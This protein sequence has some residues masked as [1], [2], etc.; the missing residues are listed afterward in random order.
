[1]KEMAEERPSPEEMLERAAQ[2]EKRATRGQ[3]KVFFGSAPGVGKTYAMLEAAQARKREGRDVVIGWVETHGRVET[4]AMTRGLERVAPRQVDYR[5]IVMQDFDLDAAL[6]RRPEILLVDELPHT[7]VAGARHAKRWQDVV[8][9]LDA[10]IDVHATLNVQ[11]IESLNDIVAQVTG[12]TV[13]ETI[14]DSLFDRANEIEFV[15]LPPEDLLQRL[16]EGKVYVPAQAERA[17]RNFFQTGNLI[18]LRELA[19]GR[20]AERVNAQSAEWRREHGMSRL[21]ATKERVLVA[22]GPAP[23]SASVIRAA[24]RIARRLRAPWIALSVETPLFQSFTPEARERVSTHLE[25]AERLG[26]E[27]LVVRG[28]RTS[29][30]ILAV[31]RQRGVTRIVVGRPFAPGGWRWRRRTLVDELIR[32]A[33]GIDVLV[34]AGEQE[35]EPSS[36]SPRSKPPILWHDYLFAAGAVGLCTLLCWWT[37][38]V[39][40]LADQAMLYLLGVLAVASRLPRA[41]SLFAAALSVAAL[42][43]FFVPPYFTFT[44]SDL[45]YVFTF[46]VMLIVGLTVSSFTVRLREQAEAARERERRTASLYA[47]SKQFVIQTEVAEIARTTISYVREL[48]ET[49]AV[50]LISGSN[51]QLLPLGTDA[52]LFPLDERELAVAQWVFEHGR[53]AGFGTDTLPATKNLYIP[54]VGTGGHLGVFGVALGDRREA[55][56]PSQWQVLET[57]VA[58]AALA[59]ERALLAEGAARSRIQ[60]ETERTR[61]V[62]LSSVSH[63][64]R[65]PLATITGAASVLLQMTG[66]LDEKNRRELL[67]TIREETERLSRLVTDLLDLTRLQSGTLQ[68]KK[69]WCPIEEPIA[70]AIGR[71]SRASQREIHQSQPESVL[72]APLD[73]VLIEQA[74]FNLIE[75]AV[76]YSAPDQAVEIAVSQGD[77][78]IVVEVLDRGPGIPRGEEEKIFERFYRAVD[79]ERSAGTGLGLTISQAIARAHG[80]D[81]EVRRREGGGT[82]FRL[83]IPIEGVPPILERREDSG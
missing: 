37:R 63:D 79:G 11:H 14:P 23:Q 56:A 4:E 47:M 13:R 69:E 64:L 48:L 46:L 76:K 67:L 43:F 83:W 60:A 26:A 39:L 24:A 5:G 28:D 31:A 73:S 25:L 51:R 6:A 68:V 36:V 57:L 53:L 35:D 27:T 71:V 74:L 70:S 61:S 78:R 55:A 45:R 58:Q 9:L 41:P 72:M 16:R 77:S 82:V 65:T 34:T 12:I 29:A 54:L 44:V 75:N 15:D 1:M 3:L 17:A 18:A 21:L 30:E 20:A 33:G 49:E 52:K 50:V 22:V 42:D 8:E 7:N 2:E 80:G 38:P 40:E 19:L 81:V 59:L 32:E 66:Q 62:L 10:G